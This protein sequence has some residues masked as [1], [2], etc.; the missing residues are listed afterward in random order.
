M[1]LLRLV[2]L[3]LVLAAPV[4]AAIPPAPER[5]EGEG[6]W[7]Q[8]ILRGVTVVTGT[9]APAYGPVDIVIEGNTIAD[10][11]TLDPVATGRGQSRRAAL[12]AARG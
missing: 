9:G 2:L 4:R 5:D 12:P 11:V 8:L 1:P 7:P 6:P 10:V 3:A